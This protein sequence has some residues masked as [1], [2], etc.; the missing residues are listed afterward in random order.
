MRRPSVAGEEATSYVLDSPP[1]PAGNSKRLVTSPRQRKKRYMHNWENI[2]GHH[3][4][5]CSPGSVLALVQKEGKPVLF[6]VVLG[7]SGTA[8]TDHQ[9]S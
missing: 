9:R 7:A 5:R 3:S 2:F 8:C 1:K 4:P 6:L